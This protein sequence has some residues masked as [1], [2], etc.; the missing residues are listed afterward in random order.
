[1]SSLFSLIDI[2]ATIG[3]L[4]IGFAA[5]SVIWGMF[6]LQVWTYY[7]RYPNDNMGYKLLLLRHE[8]LEVYEWL[9][10]A[11]EFSETNAKNHATVSKGNW[12]ITGIIIGMAL[13]QLGY[14]HCEKVC[15]PNHPM[16]FLARV[17]I[18]TILFFSMTLTLNEA[19][20]VTRIATAALGLGAATDVVTAL[21]LSYFLQ[22]MRTGYSA[23][24]TLIKRLIV[25]SVNT[26]ALT[27]LFSIS[28]VITYNVMPYNFVFMA[29]YFILCKL[30]ANSCLATLNTRRFVRGRGTD[31]Q[32]ET[33]PSFL[34][35]GRSRSG[36]VEEFKNNRHYTPAYASSR[37]LEVGVKHEISVI[38]DDAFQK[39]SDKAVDPVSVS[40][41]DMPHHTAPTYM[42]EW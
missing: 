40:S 32:T 12:I 29:C 23:S 38:S 10:L 7:L 11:I 3:A 22:K 13:A 41:P 14:V 18:G 4:I 24:D 35:V 26:G 39:T 37:G 20:R 17:L 36:A 19:T 27:S 31:H 16:V 30:Y 25:Y 1:M 15:L 33:G 8:S 34:M 21:A 6:C 42:H 28:V 2:P 9:V 5:S